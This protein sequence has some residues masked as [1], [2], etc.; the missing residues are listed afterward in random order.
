MQSPSGSSS[1]WQVPRIAFSSDTVPE[2]DRIALL[3]EELAP[4]IQLDIRFLDE[5]PRT[6]MSFVKAGPVALSSID[7][8]PIVVHRSRSFSD[9]NDDFFFNPMTAGWQQYS[10]AEHTLRLD[11]GQAFLLPVDSTGTCYFPEGGMALGLR[12]DGAALRAM[13]RHPEDLVFRA[14]DGSH[15]GMM[16]LMGYLRSFCEIR[17]SLTAELLQSFGTHI[18]DLVAA[19]LGTTRDGGAQ[20]EA[21]GVRAARLTHVLGRI[22]DCACDPGFGVEAVA[23]EL[24]LS[25]RTIQLILTET[26]STFSE[27]VAEHR[28]RRAWRLLSAPRCGLSI[29]EIALEAGFNDLSYF[30]RAF[31]RRYGETPASARAERRRL[32]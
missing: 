22:R 3:K 14:V 15:P 2:A 27:H 16:L 28:L 1:S 11:G 18:V 8:S 19:V 29:A 6:A 26:G 25:T 9:C 24:S 17:E 5:R 13:V 32:N 30:Y 21:G 7:V 4:L 10:S 31:R 23:A 20:A 12:I